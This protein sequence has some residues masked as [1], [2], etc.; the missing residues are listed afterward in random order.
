MYLFR[1]LSQSFTDCLHTAS[2]SS[3]F[4]RIVPMQSTRDINTYIQ[5]LQTMSKLGENLYEIKMQVTTS[6]FV[7]CDVCL[8]LIILY[9][10]TL[11]CDRNQMPLLSKVSNTVQ[12]I[13][14]L[15][16]VTSFT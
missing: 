16:G 6:A 11:G 5:R 1:S 15:Y 4:S 10:P 9:N 7:L 12:N 8:Y 2:V 3:V 13:F 14:C